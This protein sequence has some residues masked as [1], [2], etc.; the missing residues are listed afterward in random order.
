MLSRSW[1]VMAKSASDRAAWYCLSTSVDEAWCVCGCVCVCVRWYCFPRLLIGPCVCARACV[2]ARVDGTACLL[3][4]IRPLSLSLS[5]S[6]SLCMCLWLYAP[7]QCFFVYCV[8]LK[9][10]I[11]IRIGMRVSPFIIV[12]SFFF[13]LFI[14]LLVLLLFFPFWLVIRLHL[15]NPIGYEHV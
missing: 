4:L 12:H 11:R 14:F 9:T 5:L 1:L 2:C 3:L 7:S 10:G 8:H 15:C 13:W 6:L